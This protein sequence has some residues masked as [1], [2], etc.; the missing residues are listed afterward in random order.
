MKDVDLSKFEGLYSE[1]IS[2]VLDSMGIRK[3]AMD[4]GIRP[5]YPE[6]RIVGKAATLLV[7]DYYDEPTDE[8]YTEYIALIDVLKPGE[9]IVVK[10][11]KSSAF[12]GEL[13]A[14]SARARGAIGTIVD[15]YNRDTPMLIKMRWP[16]FS[17]G[18]Y[19]LD[20]T[21]RSKV[22][23]TNVPIV[24]GGVYVRPGDIIFADYDGIIVIPPDK[25]EEVVDSAHA[26]MRREDIVREELA[27]GEK[28][29]EVWARY[30]TL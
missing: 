24:C 13:L 15:G 3:N 29:S 20:S 27:K 17:R 9:V 23:K 21:A 2:D 1:V 10:A 18:I 25:V 6:A 28:I 11:T 26:K 19:I 8:P 16:S 14:T 5:L 22:Y 7:T 30:H 4:P 12:L